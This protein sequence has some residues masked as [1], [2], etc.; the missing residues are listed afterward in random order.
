MMTKV[1]KWITKD[2][3]GALVETFACIMREDEIFVNVI[4]GFGIARKNER[5][6]SPLPEEFSKRYSYAERQEIV[7]HANKKIHPEKSLKEIYMILMS[8]M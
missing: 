8:T 4:R 6:Y 3:A 5:G 1:E 7:N 2:P